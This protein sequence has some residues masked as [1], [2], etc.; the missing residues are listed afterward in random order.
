MKQISRRELIAASTGVAGFTFLP[1]RVLGRG[2][3]IPPSEKLNLAFVGIGARGTLDLRELAHLDQ[4]V[5]ALCDVDWRP[6]DAT[7]RGGRAPGKAAGAMPQA[8]SQIQLLGQYPQA[9]KYDDWRRMLQEEKNIDGVMVAAPDHHH[10]PVCLTAMKMAKHVYV[11]KPMCHSIEEARIMMAFEK[12]YKVTTQTGNQG[13]S[14]EDCRNV[15]EWVRDGAIGDVKLVHL[16]RRQFAGGGRR[17]EGLRS[18]M[19]MCRRFS[20]RTTQSP[21]TCSGICGLDP[22]SSA[23]YNPV[24]VPGRWRAWLDFGTGNPGDY[25]NHIFDPV[26]WALD[27]GYPNRVEADPEEGYDWAT[28]KQLYP[29]SGQMRWDFPARGKKPPVEVYYHYGEFTETVPRPPGWKEGEDKFNSIGGVLYGSKGAITFGAIHAADPLRA[30]T[31]GYRPVILGNA[32]KG[33][34]LPAGAR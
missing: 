11:E 34:D 2:G 24:Y 26:S 15:V 28:N 19:K 23:G 6:R 21:R 7:G 30:S 22:R 13:H 4:N 17:R 3:A 14:T 27:L 10:A 1:A 5:V 32:G 9:K 8:S 18:L 16:F 29:W 25:F 33:A 20:P 31:G 12:K